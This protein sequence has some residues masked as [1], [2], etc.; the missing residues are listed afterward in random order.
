MNAKREIEIYTHELDD[1]Q[2]IQLMKAINVFNQVQEVI[3]LSVFGEYNLPKVDGL[4]YWGRV[5][6][7][8]YKKD[9]NQLKVF[10]TGSRLLDNWFT[11]TFYKIAVI[12]LAD[13]QVAFLDEDKY[14]ATAPDANLLFS[15]G[16]VV[17][18]MLCNAQDFDIVHERTIGCISDLC[19]HKP[20]RAI[21]MRTAFICNKCRTLAAQAGASSIEIDAIQSILELVREF[22]SGRMPQSHVPNNQKE[23]EE[24]FIYASKLPDNTFLPPRL[25]EAC[26]DKRVTLLTGSGLSLQ[27]DVR[28]TYENKFG[29][30][31]LPSWSEIPQRLS[32][33]LNYY[34]DKMVLPRPSETLAEFLADL[35]YFRTALGEKMYYPRAIFDIFTPKI[36]SPGLVNRLIFRL[37]LNW[38]LTTNYDFILNYAAPAGTAVYTW[39][40]AMQARE[41]IGSN[42]GHP[43]LLKVHGCAS[44]PDTVVLTNSEY[45]ELNRHDEYKDLMH[46]VFQNQ[47]TLF[48]GFG[49]SDPFDLDLAIQQANLAGGAQGEKFALLPRE[50]TKEISEKFENIQIISYDRHED[51]PM[52][53]ASLIKTVT[54]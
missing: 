16:F 22:A 44:R 28:V 36:E 5:V 3:K 38:I 17:F 54:A 9:A 39:K 45:Q 25:I 46:S 41:Y 4:I 13:W 19:A 6:Q 50:K 42:N 49:L 52:I 35:D 26:K 18:L 23:E 33:V 47:V 32:Q 51:V 7:E 53:L 40:E 14:P 37:S 24:R 30:S 20:D 43:P 34:R 2:K 8:E 29:W 31:Q 27:K 10:I 11:H 1:E 15:L 12:T 21:K 48:L